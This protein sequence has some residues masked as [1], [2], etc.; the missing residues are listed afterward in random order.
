MTMNK[1]IFT[2]GCG[3]ENAGKGPFIVRTTCY[4]DKINSLEDALNRFDG[5]N[6][7]KSLWD[8]SGVPELL[9]CY[10]YEE[11]DQ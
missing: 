3:R 7:P 2:C 11:S 4:R 1:L 10:E 8:Y 6:V 9:E 5:L